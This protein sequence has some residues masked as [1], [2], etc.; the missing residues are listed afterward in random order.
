[1]TCFCPF[2]NLIVQF[3]SRAARPM[4][5]KF[6]IEHQDIAWRIYQSDT[7][8]GVTTFSNHGNHL[9]IL[10]STDS[11]SLPTCRIELKLYFFSDVHK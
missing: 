2:L 11:V 8:I 6:C 3:I 9:K 4:M 5:L 1:M 10:F 7:N